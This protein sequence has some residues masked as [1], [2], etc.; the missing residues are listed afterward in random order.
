MA[1]NLKSCGQLL[2]SVAPDGERVRS[3]LSM[4]SA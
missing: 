2:K 1:R 4:G 3:A